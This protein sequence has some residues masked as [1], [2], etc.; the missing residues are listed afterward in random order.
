MDLNAVRAGLDVFFLK[1]RVF[2]GNC[3]VFV[4]GSDPDVALRNHRATSEPNQ[5]R[6][7]DLAPLSLGALGTDVRQQLEALAH[8]LPPRDS[9]CARFYSNEAEILELVYV[10]VHELGYTAPKMG[11]RLEPGVMTSRH[12]CVLR[13]KYLGCDRLEVRI[14]DQSGRS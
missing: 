11:F 14:Y 6:D 13:I 7:L 10:I 5:G 2:T 9:R 4:V 1:G 12:P 3:L 8:A